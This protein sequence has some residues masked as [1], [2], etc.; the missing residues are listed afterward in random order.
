M[1]QESSI[2]GALIVETAILGAITVAWWI[3][4]NRASNVVD[5]L[6]KNIAKSSRIL[7]EVRDHFFEEDQ[8]FAPPDH[9]EAPEFQGDPALPEYMNDE[10]EAKLE[11]RER[12]TRG[13]ASSGVCSHWDEQDERE[14]L[15]EEIRKFEVMRKLQ[16]LKR[17]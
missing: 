4:L 14:A 1:D 7:R 12:L 3:I 5:D 9:R 11:E 17:G 2:L 8:T 6:G 15:D 16:L 10:I 13:A